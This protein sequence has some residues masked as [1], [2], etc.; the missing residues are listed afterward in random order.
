MIGAMKKHLV[1]LWHKAL[2]VAWLLMFVFV[3]I[4]VLLSLF[5][6]LQAAQVVVVLMGI[7][8]AMLLLGAFMPL[9]EDWMDWFRSAPEEDP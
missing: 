6:A 8:L 9:F 1:Y 3:V 5:G 7:C 4:A 2:A